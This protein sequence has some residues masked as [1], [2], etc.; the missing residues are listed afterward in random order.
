MDGWPIVSFSDW[1]GYRVYLQHDDSLCW[2]IKS[3]LVSLLVTN[4]SENL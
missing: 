3:K 1:V 4:K 2:H